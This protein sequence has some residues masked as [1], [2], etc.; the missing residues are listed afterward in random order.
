MSGSVHLNS[1]DLLGSKVNTGYLVS[2]QPADYT[3]LSNNNR[4]TIPQE[5]VLGYKQMYH[6]I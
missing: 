6:F 3:R 2:S 1:Q 5:N 4:P